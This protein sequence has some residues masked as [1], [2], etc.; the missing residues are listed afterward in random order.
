[1]LELLDE[2]VGT[3]LR[4]DEH[5]CATAFVQLLNQSVE[6]GVDRHR[7]EGVLD[8][9]LLTLGR[10]RCREPRRIA[11]VT[12][13]EFRDRPLERGREEHRLA[14]LRNCAQ[15]AVDLRLEAHVEHP[16]RLV[17]DEHTH[18]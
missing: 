9:A 1:M 5:E 11:R 14:V 10:R 15:D 18:A 12:R 6:L 16:V 2:L 17:E 8:L 3:V 4:P 7:H 13:S